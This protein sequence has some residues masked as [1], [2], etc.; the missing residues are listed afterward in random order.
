MVG[1]INKSLYMT[2]IK[3]YFASNNYRSY[4]GNEVAGF[5]IFSQ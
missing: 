4:E 2:F 1:N 5:A 3:R